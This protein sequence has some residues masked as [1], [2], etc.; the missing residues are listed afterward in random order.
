MICESIMY[1]LKYF[2]FILLN[3]IKWTSIKIF[4]A[5]VPKL[6]DI[7]S[8]KIHTYAS[9]LCSHLPFW[10]SLQCKHVFPVHY[11]QFYCFCLF[12]FSSLGGNILTVSSKHK[13]EQ[14]GA[15]KLVGHKLRTIFVASFIAYHIK[16]GLLR[17]ILFC[18]VLSVT[19]YL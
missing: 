11:L 1:L 13:A 7:L 6:S 14:N 19:L 2:N 9:C 16:L 12:C 8:P 4:Y 5:I 17:E 10:H 18:A 3:Y 15:A